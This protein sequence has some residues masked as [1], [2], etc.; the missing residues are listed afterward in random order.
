[1]KRQADSLS[2]SLASLRFFARH[3]CLLSAHHLRTNTWVWML[4]RLDCARWITLVSISAFPRTCRAT[5]RIHRLDYLT[6]R[7]IPRH[8]TALCFLAHSAQRFIRVNLAHWSS[9]LSSYRSPFSPPFFRFSLYSF[10]HILIW[11]HV[12]ISS[13]WKQLSNIQRV[14]LSFRFSLYSFAHIVIWQ[15][16]FIS[17]TWKQA[18]QCRIIEQ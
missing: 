14:L 10:T 16:V 13:A 3:A 6:W 17:S 2:L 12:F 4:S 5:D 8:F 7:C 18:T 9:L 15:H 11:Q 1:M